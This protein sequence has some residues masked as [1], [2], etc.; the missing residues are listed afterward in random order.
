MPW[1]VNYLTSVRLEIVHL[2]G[3]PEANVRQLCRR[4]EI[5]PTVGYK[6]I[7]RFEA[8]GVADLADRSRRPQRSSKRTASAWRRRWWRCAA[9]SQLK[10]RSFSMHN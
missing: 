8:G 2:A 6:W 4:F 3:W 10:L 1:L 5:S 9:S 7:D